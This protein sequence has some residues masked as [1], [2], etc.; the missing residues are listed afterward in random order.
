M[1]AAENGGFITIDGRLGV[2]LVVELLGVVCRDRVLVVAEYVV[3]DGAPAR[4]DFVQER[5]AGIDASEPVPALGSSVVSLT[6][7]PAA[8]AAT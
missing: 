2:A 7:A 4:V 1:P 5:G 3:E 8:T 6:V